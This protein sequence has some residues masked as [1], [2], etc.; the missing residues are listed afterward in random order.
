MDELYI[1]LA[2]IHRL[3]PPGTKKP[4][5]GGPADRQ[6]TPQRAYGETSLDHIDITFDDMLDPVKHARALVKLYS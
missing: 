2:Q 6:A 5:S 4:L 1:L 3:N